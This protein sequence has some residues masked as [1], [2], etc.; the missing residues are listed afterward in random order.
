MKRTRR[1]NFWQTRRNLRRSARD[2]WHKTRSCN[3]GSKRNKKAANLLRLAFKVS[4]SS[5]FSSAKAI[6]DHKPSHSNL[7]LCI[8]PLLLLILLIGMGSAKPGGNKTLC[9]AMSSHDLISYIFWVVTA[10][11]KLIWGF[12]QLGDGLRV[13]WLAVDKLTRTTGLPAS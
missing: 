13:V 12:Y 7:N 3:S 1:L 4:S 8:C 5:S 10:I 11:A 2:I 6:R 9:Q